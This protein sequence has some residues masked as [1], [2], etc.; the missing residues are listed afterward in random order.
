MLLSMSL[1]ESDMATEQAN[2]KR[3]E[4]HDDEKTEV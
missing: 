1:K 3:R 4:R 2:Q